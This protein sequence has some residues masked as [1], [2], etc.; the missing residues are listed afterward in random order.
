MRPGRN[1]VD[2]KDEEGTESEDA[3]EDTAEP[4]TAMGRKVIN[5]SVS[6]IRN[7]A[8]RHGRN[9]DWAESA[10]RDA[11]TLSAEDALEQ[12]V[13]DV[14]AENRDDLLVAIDGREVLLGSDMVAIATDSPTIEQYEPSWRIKFLS[15]AVGYKWSNCVF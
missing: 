5:D 9:A 15:S 7:L 3:A 6:Y 4:S 13:I 11:A 8:D 2:S 12:N 1:P 14:I 10:V